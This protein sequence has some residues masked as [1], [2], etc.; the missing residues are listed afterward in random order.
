MKGVRFID[1]LSAPALRAG[2]LTSL[3]SI[4]RSL[5]RALPRSQHHAGDDQAPQGAYLRCAGALRVRIRVKPVLRQQKT[6][7]TKWFQGFLVVRG[8]GLELPFLFSILCY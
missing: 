7:E 5:L 6:L 2:A 8:T 4:C 3:C 1:T